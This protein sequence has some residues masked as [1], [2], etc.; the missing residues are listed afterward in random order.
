[1][2]NNGTGEALTTVTVVTVPELRRKA[3]AM[4]GTFCILPVFSQYR[5]HLIALN[6]I[7][8]D[9]IWRSNFGGAIETGQQTFVFKISVGE[10]CCERR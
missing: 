4:A 3:K 10:K 6:N 9:H 1:M 8:S 7:V 2:G 5:P